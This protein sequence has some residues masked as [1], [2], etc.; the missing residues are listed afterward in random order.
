[1]NIQLHDNWLKRLKPEF[2]KPYMQELRAFLLAEKNAGKTIYPK[3]SEIFNALN[4]TLFDDVK[5]VIIGQDPY[6]GPSQAHG[7]SFSVR[8]GQKTPP[9]LQN[10]YKELQT[11]LNCTIPNHGELL[12]WATQGVLLL[13][14]ILTVEGNKAASHHNRGWEQFTNAVIEE[15]NYSKEN[16]VFMLWGKYAQEKGSIIDA[17]KH[18]VLR[19]AHPSPFSAYNGFFGCKHFSQCNTFLQK[20]GKEAI[21]WQIK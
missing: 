14:A 11:D 20:N 1:M 21:D 6:H 3:G 2:D 7:L 17:N 19:A 16:L 5:V 8:K 13:N 12:D 18:M 15:L 10:I 9:S 4:T